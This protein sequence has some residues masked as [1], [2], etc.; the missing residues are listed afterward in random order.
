VFLLK[1]SEKLLKTKLRGAVLLLVMTVM[2]MLM[3]LL[4]ATLAVVSSSNKKAYVKFEENQAFYS[5]VSA[6]EV[7][8]DG[9]LS[10]NSFIAADSLTGAAK[11]YVEADGTTA[12]GVLTQGRD[13]EL[14]LYKLEPLSPLGGLD[15]TQLNSKINGGTSAD[16]IKFFSADETALDFSTYAQYAEQF[17]MEGAFGSAPKEVA[18]YVEYPDVT[19]PTTGGYGRYADINPNA[20]T[21]K[22]PQVATVKIEVLD[23]YY[24]IAGVD[25]GALMNF[26][27]DTDTDPTT[28][29]VPPAIAHATIPDKIDNA[30]LDQALHRSGDRTKD[31]F[32]I[33][34][35]SESMLMGV[36][37]TAAVE[38]KSSAPV[39]SVPA[40]DTAIKS[41]G[42]TE[43]G[44]AGYNAVGGA[45]G[46]AD[47]DVKNGNVYGL[48][49]SEGNIVFD[50]TGS[51]T[52]ENSMQFKTGANGNYIVSKPHIYSKSWITSTNSQGIN[53]QGTEMFVYAERGMR[54]GKPLEE[55]GKTTHYITNGD[56]IITETLGISGNLVTGRYGNEE[57]INA[58][59]VLTVGKNMYVKEFYLD[60]VDA[61][62][63]AFAG[64]SFGMNPSRAVVSG[65]TIY[66]RD[67]YLNFP[68][69]E[70]RDPSTI[71]T[72]D[73]TWDAATGLQQGEVAANIGYYD[74]NQ[75]TLAAADMSP[76]KIAGGA[77]RW[78]INTKF[79][80]AGTPKIVVSGQVY[81][82]D[83]ATGTYVGRDWNDLLGNGGT[84]GD[85]MNDWFAFLSNNVGSIAPAG[86][87]YDISSNRAAIDYYKAGDSSFYNVTN[88]NE[89]AWD[90]N[91]DVSNANNSQGISYNSYLAGQSHSAAPQIA[92]GINDAT[93]DPSKA[94][95]SFD[96]SSGHVWLRMPF[97]VSDGSNTARAIIKFDTPQSLYKDFFETT[98]SFNT[99]TQPIDGNDDRYMTYDPSAATHDDVL[100]YGMLTGKYVGPFT[101]VSATKTYT[102]PTPVLPVNTDAQNRK[103][104]TQNFGYV[105]D[106]TVAA[107]QIGI[108]DL[109]KSAESKA[110]AA[111]WGTSSVVFD[112]GV[113]DATSTSAGPSMQIPSLA[114][115]GSGTTVKYTGKITSDGVA[116]MILGGTYQN[117]TNN[118]SPLVVI[119]A[120]TSGKTVVIKP[121]YDTTTTYTW[122]DDGPPTY[123]NGHL[124]V[125]TEKVG[126]VIG[127]Y[128]V[129]GDF[130][131]SFIIKDEPGANRVI[132]GGSNGNQTFNIISSKRLNGNISLSQDTKNDGSHYAHGLNAVS[133]QGAVRLAVGSNET[134]PAEASNITLYAGSNTD[135]KLESGTI[136]GTIYAP[137]SKFEFAAM[138]SPSLGPT[139][140]DESV[141]SSPTSVMG[142]I[143]CGTL[144]WNNEQQV[145]F[146]PSSGG[147]TTTPG[148]PHFNWSPMVYTA[149]ASGS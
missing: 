40:A 121:K 43:D 39:V 74:N 115:P 68:V 21:G 140:N 54:I 50:S 133:T 98:A 44:G 147:S 89:Y 26:L 82:R 105:L 71:G 128:I 77:A 4:M 138:N 85:T 81:F 69:S 111:A 104:G 79:T 80:G 42:F 23:R 83:Y 36:K 91:P 129:D 47:M 19:S 14:E 146:L 87:V 13:L 35:T 124:E 16:L 31:L 56:F 78:P 99:G 17:N 143:V 5:A 137:F 12:A 108:K 30:K 102:L 11:N 15:A 127:T 29:P 73:L 117:A 61:L 18:F 118:L 8:W 76:I 6:L 33:R 144:K 65:G 142:T 46:L 106:L 93:G 48:L 101:Y 2:F 148:L 95:F 100:G 132:L 45:S 130:P 10:D 38:L 145:I 62:G 110:G 66:V 28:N 22:A 96:T 3:I 114:T 116:E 70:L 9:A 126:T 34:V 57:T 53:I 109:V 75:N 41:F 60:D 125:V 131:V 86:G 37:G 72:T 103:N 107:T 113:A 25:Q 122:V 88:N 24:D 49:Y 7:F 120:T 84:T 119:D 136:D 141:S 112:F 134:T 64:N 52:A 90:I 51:V 20:G 63:N 94:P 32:D 97:K 27:K 92:A 135:I 59:K 55:T 139:F 149:N 123:A 67:L 58:S 1:N